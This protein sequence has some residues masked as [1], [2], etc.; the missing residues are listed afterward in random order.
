MTGPDDL[1]TS[2]V[3][4][5]S[6]HGGDSLRMCCTGGR[7]GQT[8]AFGGGVA[9]VVASASDRARLSLFLNIRFVTGLRT[10][11][12]DSGGGGGRGCA[13]KASGNGRDE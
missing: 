8:I 9:G 11:G 2:A 6:E 12:G 7:L 1:P 5:L 10:G 13:G 3:A 4:R